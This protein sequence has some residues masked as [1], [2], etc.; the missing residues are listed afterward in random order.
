MSGRLHIAVIAK[1]PPGGRCR[2][3]FAFAEALAATLGA[4]TETLL[5]P[6]APALTVNGVSI[7]PADGVILTADELH[8][9]LARAGRALPE[10]LLATLEAAEDRFMEDLAS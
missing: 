4:T 7:V 5:G 6:E 8:A 9:G 10:G 3:Y 2:L 1:E